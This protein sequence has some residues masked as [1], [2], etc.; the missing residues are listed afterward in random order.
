LNIFNIYLLRT[1]SPMAHG[2]NLKGVQPL[3]HATEGK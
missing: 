2:L 1:A 3:V